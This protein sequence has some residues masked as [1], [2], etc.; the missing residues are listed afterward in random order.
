MH[1]NINIISLNL[2]EYKKKVYRPV[3]NPMRSG[4]LATWYTVLRSLLKP[5][6]FTASAVLHFSFSFDGELQPPVLHRKRV[7]VI[8]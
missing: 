4:L 1:L 2:K 5:S 7:K 6:P 8:W 3:K